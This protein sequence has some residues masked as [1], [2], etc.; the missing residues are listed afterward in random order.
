MRGFFV[1][2]FIILSVN[3]NAQNWQAF[4]DSIPTLSSPRSSDLNG[5][6]VLDIVIGG[7]TDGVFS[8][9]GIMAYNG[10][11]GSL[12]WKRSS[13]NEVFGSAIFQDLT[14]D[15]I[16][17]VII[18]GRE[19]QL[20]AINGTNGDLLWDY[21]PYGTNPADS[22]LYNFYNPQFIH[23]V[24]GDTY[25]DIL[26]SNGGDHAAPAWETDR[27]PGY[28][29]VVSAL[30]G[31][32]IVRAV[33]PDSAEIYCSVIV[34]DIQNDGNQWILYGTGGENFGG[35]FYAALLDDLLLGDLTGSIILGSDP[36]K[37]FVAPAAIHKK[38]SGVYDIIIQSFD[39]L[40]TKI[41]GETWAPIWTY[42]KPGT[43]SSAEPVIGNFTGDLT[44][45]I[46]LVLFK[47]I[48]PSYSDYYQVMLNGEDGSVSFIDSLGAIDFASANAADLDNN[49]RDEGIY[50][51]TYFEGGCFKSRIESIDFATNSI[52]T[53]DQTR[54]GVTIGSTPLFTDL[55][56]DG[57]MDLVYSVKKDSL[58]PM[59]W[60]GIY[61]YRHELSSI[62]PNSG[63]AWGSYLGTNTD[64]IY[65]LESVDC[66]FGS[67]IS[68]VNALNPN[69]NG[70]AN[71][72]ISLGLAGASP[73]TYFWS[74]GS[75]ESS[76]QNIAAGSYWVQ[77]TNSLG[78]YEIRTIN[79]VDPYVI[80]FGGIVPP[81]CIGDSNGMA[82]LNSTGCYC[83]F[84]GCVFLWDNGITTKPNSSLPEG[85]S[86]VIITHLDGCVVVDSVFVPSPPPVIDSLT[87]ENIELCFGD[88]SGSA[89]VYYDQA[90]LP[91]T[92]IWSTGET[93]DTI[94][95]LPAGDY[96]VLAQD[97]RPCMDSIAFT[98]T[99]PDSLGFTAI[100]SDV[101][102]F[103]LNDG[104][105]SFTGSGGTE[106]LNYFYNGNS[107]LNNVVTGLSPN[108]YD[109]Y[110]QD[111]NGCLSVNQSV[112]IVE[113]TALSLTI[114][115]TSASGLTSL[116][117]IAEVAITGGTLPYL[118]TWNDPNSQT[119]EMAVYL[120]PGWYTATVMDDNGCSIID[121]VY[122][123]VLGIEDMLSENL[124]FYPNPA[125]DI[126][127]FG[128]EVIDIE[129][130]DLKGS[131]IYAKQPENGTI[132][133]SM[134]S[135]VYTL[136]LA[137]K[138]SSKRAK[139]IVVE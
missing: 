71:G 17:D 21:F 79:L 91:V 67:V 139:L 50:S 118:T 47:G 101:T 90:T 109:L 110:I 96:Y 28:L 105:I 3:A 134:A 6:G 72:S 92:F 53:L 93:N 87:F 60:K 59:G 34:E 61:V 26:V 12:L 84:S 136:V 70:F 119:G 58:N 82:T 20:L 131:L 117:G 8:N 48:A 113:P 15:G 14:A 43:E 128:E 32:L 27:P 11:D 129:I 74:T 33:V 10:V 38:N 123:G 52:N 98:I 46:L 44:P 85:W 16:D 69:C 116:D 112:T 51:I 127:Q 120:N 7:G 94:I 18:V 107:S 130:Y 125:K 36:N 100:A 13:R 24:D 55:D 114:S 77:V 57:L 76:I 40:V 88:L 97:G 9:N 49:G 106:P 124:F 102:C 63:I 65:N 2:L 83:M 103:D 39:G 37:G 23:D 95:G 30:T 56:N 86:S 4:T 121:S 126:I 89:I 66:G 35:H 132:N 62:L 31:D 45:D 54:T 41:A 115:G 1:S 111:Q 68:S 138:T 42:Q 64:G 133:L 108:T 29:M 80:S 104:T 99:Q 137:G 5:D 75:T 73:Y 81:T 122:L 22:G 135:G 19:A 25:P 78:C